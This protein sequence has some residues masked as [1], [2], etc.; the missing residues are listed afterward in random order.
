MAHSKASALTGQLAHKW[1]PCTRRWLTWEGTKI[2]TIGSPPA[3]GHLADPILPQNKQPVPAG[4]RRHTHDRGQVRRAQLPLAELQGA[5]GFFWT[6]AEPLYVQL[7]ECT[8]ALARILVQEV[9][10]SFLCSETSPWTAVGDPASMGPE[11][12]TSQQRPQAPHHGRSHFGPGT[13]RH[14]VPPTLRLDQLQS[15]DPDR[16]EPIRS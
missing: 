5:C 8:V 2:P 13:R 4:R 9:P 7:R 16:D 12:P 6:C 11:P 10:V 1:V 14:F 3:A 15:S